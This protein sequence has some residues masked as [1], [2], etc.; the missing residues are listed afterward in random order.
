MDDAAQ[1]AK[2]VVDPQI[3]HNVYYFVLDMYARQDVLETYFGIDNK[4]FLANLERLGFAV[5]RQSLSNYGTTVRTI[6]TAFNM[7]F[8]IPDSGDYEV[9]I[10]QTGGRAAEAFH[11]RGY[12]FY[13]VESGGFEAITC[14]RQVDYCVKGSRVDQVGRLLLTMTPLWRLAHSGFVLKT[15][16]TEGMYSLSEIEPA[17]SEILDYGRGRGPYL[18]F[19]HILSP[20]GP[21][22]YSPDCERLTILSPKFGDNDRRRYTHDLGCLNPRILSAM[23]NILANDH[24]DPI[25]LLQSDHGVRRELV[26]EPDGKLIRIKNLSATRA[27]Q[28]CRDLLNQRLTPVNNFRFALACIDDTKPAYIED[29]FFQLAY[30]DKDHLLDFTDIVRRKSER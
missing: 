30:P 25:I 15:F 1:A 24:S 4:P 21:A 13:F 9:E 16:A 8:Y 19:V 20:H 2:Q 29:R 23:K 27:P 7:D 6:S 10:L 14:G 11:K 17:V 5:D 28:R 3:A 26:G 12:S 22:R 18:A